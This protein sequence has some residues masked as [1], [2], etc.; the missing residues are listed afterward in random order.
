MYTV[1]NSERIRKKIQE[2]INNYPVIKTAKICHMRNAS[3]I[4]VRYMKGGCHFTL[5]I[6]EFLLSSLL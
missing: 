5:T 1:N 2:H 3:G 4:Y 6:N